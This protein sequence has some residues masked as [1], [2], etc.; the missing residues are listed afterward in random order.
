MRDE[1]EG[2]K[3]GGRKTEGSLREKDTRAYTPRRRKR[4]VNRNVHARQLRP[5]HAC[6]RKEVQ[7]G[8]HHGDVHGYAC[9]PTHTQR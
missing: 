2:R 7:R 8:I 9:T 4:L 5:V 6:E 3:E 1:M